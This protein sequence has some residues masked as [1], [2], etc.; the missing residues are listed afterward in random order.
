VPRTD[1]VQAA[2][3]E[4]G[5]AMTLFE[6]KRHAQVFRDF[7]AGTAPT[8]AAVGTAAD[9]ELAAEAAAEVPN[10]RASRRTPATSSSRRS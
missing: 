5:S 4:V 9:P 2:R 1:F 10:A 7:L 6:V 3:N 8:S